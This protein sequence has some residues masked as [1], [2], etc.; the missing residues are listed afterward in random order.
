MT[1]TIGNADNLWIETR[2]M[3]GGA[4]NQV[5][6]SENLSPF[7]S[8]SGSLPEEIEIRFEGNL[9]TERPVSSRTTD[10]PYDVPICLVYLPTGFDYSHKFIH[11][12]KIPTDYFAPRIELKMASSGDD[13]IDRWRD[14]SRKS[15][16]IGETNGG[17]EYG[18]Y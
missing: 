9:Y 16:V 13:I 7:F 12:E 5:E 8:Y 10:P 14:S 1:T 17:R 3:T 15:G 11:F 18:Y 4:R 6:F 2:E